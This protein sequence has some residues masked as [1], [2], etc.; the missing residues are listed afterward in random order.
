MAVL[1]LE[2]MV[3]GGHALARLRG[4]RVALVRGGIP[5]ELVEVDLGVR[6][7]VVTGKVTRIVEASE[8]RVEANPHPGLDYSFISYPAQLVCKRAVVSDA[9]KRA[10]GKDYTVPELTPSPHIWHYRHAVQPAATPSGLGYRHQDSRQVEVLEG[11]DPTAHRAINSAWSRWSEVALGKGGKGVAEVAYRC[12]DAGEVLACL[13]ARASPR[14]YLGVAHELIRR[15]YAGVAYAAYDPRGRFR[16]GSERLAGA[17]SIRQTYG[18]FQVEVN[19]TSFAQPNPGA[20]SLL[21]GQLSAVAPTG[22]TA[23]DL[24]AGNGVIAMHVAANFER[25]LAVELDRGSV[26]RGRRDAKRAGVDNIEFVQADVKRMNS[27]AGADTIFVDPPRAG[28]AKPVREAIIASPVDRLVYV[29]CDVAT[30][31]RDVAHFTAAG[32]DLALLQPYDFFPH[33]H[34]V[35]VLSL[36]RRA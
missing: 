19:A 1:K 8:H 27:F 29:S 24:Y 3:H 13:I 15:G 34:H 2:R 5:G 20:A 32:F 4:G 11:G 6:S 14:N 17:R 22:N 23:L 7:G 21:Y 30:W 10:T 33:T 26:T 12:N 18:R 28:V 9:L 25:V 31:A 35:E 36:L 16:S